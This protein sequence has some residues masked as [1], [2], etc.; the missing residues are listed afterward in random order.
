MD[1][2]KQHTRLTIETA[3]NGIVC[4][5]CYGSGDHEDKQYVYKNIDQVAKAL[6]GIFSVA[7]AEAPTETHESLEAMKA[8]L[9]KEY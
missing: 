2:S 6:T 3:E 8:N 7:E 4:T 9:P 1:K 5:V